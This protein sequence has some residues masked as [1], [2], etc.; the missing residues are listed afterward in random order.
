MKVHNLFGKVSRRLIPTFLKLLQRKNPLNAISKEKFREMIVE[1]VG[2]IEVIERTTTPV[3]DLG[4]AADYRTILLAHYNEILELRAY[5]LR[6]SD[7]MRS[8]HGPSLC[9]TSMSDIIAK[10][11]EAVDVGTL[12]MYIRQ[13]LVLD[14]SGVCHNIHKAISHLDTM[15]GALSKLLSIPA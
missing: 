10:A 2:I 6:C 14:V 9:T 4:G 12:E 8:A 11:A 1:C 15:I 13:M 7:S 3:A 5:L